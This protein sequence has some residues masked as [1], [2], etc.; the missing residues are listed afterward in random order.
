[1]ARITAKGS[2][3]YLRNLEKLGRNTDDICKQAVYQGAK[4]VA[5]A[6]KSSID[7]ITMHSLPS[8]QKYFYLS[9]EDKKGGKLLDGVTKE[10]ADGLKNGLGIAV[11]EHKNFAWNTKIGFNGYNEVRTKTY[12]KG[13]P[14]ALIA[15]SVESGSSVRNKTPFIAPAVKKKSA[16]MQSTPWK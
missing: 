15:R 13:E 1:M 8:G 2:A 11:M 3:Q 14:N 10:Q 9:E 4:V 6:I 12:P 7:D 5:D 16:R